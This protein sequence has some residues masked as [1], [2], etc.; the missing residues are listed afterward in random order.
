MG[1]GGMRYGAGRPAFKGKAE[2]CMRLDVRDLARRRALAPGSSGS[3]SWTV[4]RTGE[5]VGSIGYRMEAGALVLSYS[6]NGDPRAQRV[7]ILRTPCNYGNTRPWFACPHCMARVAVIYMRRG[8]FY[9]RKCAQVAYSSQSEDVCGRSWR[10]QQKAEAKLGKN[11]QRPKGMHETT[12]ERLIS[13][14]G[15]CEEARDFEL[16]AFIAGHAKWL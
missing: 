2:A 14:I 4:T 13:M 5:E 7:P 11:W 1:S 8:G 16:A 6:I 15:E 9:C 3:W 10:V 12:Y